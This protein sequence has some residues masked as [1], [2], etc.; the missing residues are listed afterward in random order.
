MVGGCV[1]EWVGGWLNG[2][3]V[4]LTDGWLVI[5]LVVQIKC[6]LIENKCEF[7]CREGTVWNI[8]AYNVRVTYECMW[9]I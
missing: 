2:W 4:G 9:I 6:E 1:N 3:M 5:Y 8:L 7:A